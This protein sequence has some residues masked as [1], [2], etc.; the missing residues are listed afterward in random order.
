MRVI[1]LPRRASSSIG[2]ARCERATTCLYTGGWPQNQ[3]SSLAWR[4]EA[5]AAHR[6]QIWTAL[7]GNGYTMTN[8][9]MSDASSLLRR[10]DISGRRRRIRACLPCWQAAEMICRR[11]GRLAACRSAGGISA[12]IYLPRGAIS[13]GRWPDRLPFED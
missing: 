6:H 1:G 12:D 7:A 10:V 11:G 5:I 2:A 8:E 9:V 3:P 13:T 4:H